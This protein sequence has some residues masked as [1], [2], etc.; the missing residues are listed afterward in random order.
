MTYSIYIKSILNN[1]CNDDMELWEYYYGIDPNRIGIRDMKKIFEQIW[2]VGEIKDINKDIEFIKHIQN[3]K[4]TNI[5]VIVHIEE[6][7]LY[8]DS[9]IGS[10]IINKLSSMNSEMSKFWI[11]T[12]NIHLG[13]GPYFEMQLMDEQMLYALSCHP[14]YSK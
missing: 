6:S 11:S 5:S 1:E 4:L 14:I 10:Q 7:N 2:S 9:L 3:G 8:V 13:H 12:D